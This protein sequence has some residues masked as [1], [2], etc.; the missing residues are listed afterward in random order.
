MVIFFDLLFYEIT[1][2]EKYKFIDTHVEKL[3]ENS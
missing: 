1:F 3:E 2:F